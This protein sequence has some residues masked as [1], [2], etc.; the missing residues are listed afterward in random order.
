MIRGNKALLLSFTIHTLIAL[1]AVALYQHWPAK[2]GGEI[3]YKIAL[4]C[5][6][7]NAAAVKEACIEAPA[8]VAEKERRAPQPKRIEAKKP[9]PEPLVN[10]KKSVAKPAAAEKPEA[11][12]PVQT[13]VVTSEADRAEQKEAAAEEA[14]EAAPETAEEGVEEELLEASASIPP[15]AAPSVESES[16]EALPAAVSA[17]ELYLQEHIRQIALLLRENL[18]YPRIARKRGITGDVTVAFELLRNG[19][20]RNVDVVTGERAILNRAAIKTIERLSGEF[21]KPEEPL[22]LQVPINYRLQ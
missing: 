19:E 9:A 10:E 14:A 8:Q 17:E 3:R 11:S 2:Q 18:Y 20:V 6:L 13:A 5:L 21:P 15:A 4:S 22:T 7:E 1:F 12:V 16:A